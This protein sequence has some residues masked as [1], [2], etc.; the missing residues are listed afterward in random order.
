MSR[1]RSAGASPQRSS[2]SATRA[3]VSARLDVR[4]WI[5]PVLGEL[6]ERPDGRCELVGSTSNAQAYAGEWLAGIPFPFTVVGGDELRAAV[7]EV[8]E[9]LSRAVTQDARPGG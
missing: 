3:R 8:G 1:N 5:R 7:A 9:R 6:R 2:I 4:P